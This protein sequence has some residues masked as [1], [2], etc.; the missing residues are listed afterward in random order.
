MKTYAIK[1]LVTLELEAEGL[2]IEEANRTINGMIENFEDYDREDLEII[3]EE[4]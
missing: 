1:N 4:E 2:T 3:E